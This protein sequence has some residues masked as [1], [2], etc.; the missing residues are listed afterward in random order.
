MKIKLTVFALALII[1]LVAASNEQQRQTFGQ[2]F[3]SSLRFVRSGGI[4]MEG[5][6]IDL[7]VN[8]NTS[9]IAST[10]DQI[11]FEVGGS[12][13]LSITTSGLVAGSGLDLNGQSLTIDVDGNTTLTGDT[14]DQIDFALGGSDQFVMKIP[15]SPVSGSQTTQLFETIATSPAF[16]DGTNAMAA[17]NVDLAIGNSTG[18]TNNVY[19]VLIDDIS[20]DAQNTETAISIGGTGW[21]VGLDAGANTI[22]NIGAAG[23]DFN[24][25][26]GLTLASGL[27]TSDG[28]VVVAD[29]L[30]TTAQSSQVVTNT[31]FTATGTYQRVTATEE[32]TPT[33]AAGATA[34]AAGIT[35]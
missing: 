9:I 15:P 1:L 16:T 35:L 18:G 32:V 30:R 2:V 28:D 24:S 29:D 10:D 12:N 7:D 20:P 4:Q 6:R 21:D 33:I 13:V 26:G 31:T 19:G 34:G 25:S 17:F 11:D 14:D 5:N 23:T 3:V 27:T 8:R 22:L